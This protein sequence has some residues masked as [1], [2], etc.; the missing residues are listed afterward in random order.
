MNAN[1][2]TR[3]AIVG[4][5]GRFPKAPNVDALWQ[6][7]K[8]G[9]ECLS[10]LDREDLLEAGNPPEDVDHPDYVPMAGLIE[11]ADLFDARLFGFSPKEADY[12]DPQH[13]VFLE[14]AMQALED[15]GCNPHTFGGAISIY[16]GAALSVYQVSTI[17]AN[18]KMLSESESLRTLFAIGIAHDYLATRVSYKLG[19]RGPAVTVQTACSTSLVAIHLACQSLL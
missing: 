12:I 4:M 2:D 13:R 10:T 6:A 7:L 3:I 18:Y 9:R 19:M 17:L 1:Q 5:A 14:V 11:G 8:E 16:A 15:S